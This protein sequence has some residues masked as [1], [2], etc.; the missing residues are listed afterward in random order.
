MNTNLTFLQHTLI[1]T[2]H[3]ED[4]PEAASSQSGVSK[5]IMGKLSE[6]KKCLLEWVHE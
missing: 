2:V 3:N 6:G 4:V 1:S 5:H